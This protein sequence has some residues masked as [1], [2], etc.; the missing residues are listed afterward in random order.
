MFRACRAQAACQAGFPNLRRECFRTVRKLA[1]HPLA[2]T[3]P[4]LEG[5]GRVKIVFDGWQMANLFVQMSV[6]GRLDD[7]PLMINQLAHGHGRLAGEE[8]LKLAPSIPSIIG[9]GLQWGVYCRE[10]AAFTTPARQLAIS[11]RA[12]PQFP[13]GILRLVPQ[14]PR[15]FGD[16]AA[17]N[18][19]K[20]APDTR[21]VVRSNLPVLLMSGTFDSQWPTLAAEKACLS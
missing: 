1:R 7:M 11:R 19:G 15:V 10:E 12:L 20:A 4:A 13:A 9:Y 5:N 2:L 6:A 21:D 18:V 14:I 17:W 8:L 3:V 16:C